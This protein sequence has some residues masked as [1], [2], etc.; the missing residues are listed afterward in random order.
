MQLAQAILPAVLVVTLVLQA[1][2]PRYRLMIVM[3]GAGA[4]CL[5]TSMLGLGHAAQILSDVP[6]DV[7]VILVG[8]GLVS[9]VFVESRVFGVLA[10]RACRWSGADPR[11][12]SLL[13]AVGMYSHG[14]LVNNLTALLLILPML[15][16]LYKLVG[17][18]QRYVSWSIGLLL[19]ACN[20]GGAATPIGDFPAV[21]LLGGG[22]MGFTAYLVRALPSTLIGLVVVV[23][24]VVFG[25]RPER[26]LSKS[27]VSAAI[28]VDTMGALYRSVRVDRRMLIPAAIALGTMIVAWMKLPAEK[29]WTPEL[30]CWLGAGAAL[31]VKPSLGERLIRRKVDV[32]AVLFLLGLFVMVVAARR[33][34]I[35]TSVA[36]ALVAL[37]ISPIAQ[38]VVFVIA[39]G[40]LTSLFSAGP[41]M[42]SLL[43]VADVLA[44]QHPPNTVYVGLAL[45]V[46]AGSSLFTTAATSGPLAQ[47]LTERADLRD[48]EGRP[49]RF[50]F[51]EFL[52][53]GILSFL[54]IEAVAIGYCLVTVHY[55]W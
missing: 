20:L 52:P 37:P 2:W 4:S 54:V 19:V 1:V 14:G 26:G 16:G 53:V 21:L 43:E 27:P 6:W 49:L 18:T 55:G 25:V 24:L 45:G 9:E 44:R 46:C 15:L 3:A 12:I 48:S 5:T 33:S 8:L 50:G 36:H 30:I 32:E 42:A 28:T 35:F 13:F 38:L 51:V 31:A 23:S 11:K 22:K 29:G 17:V 47:A 34:G 7:L 40:L 41:S 10:M 39:A